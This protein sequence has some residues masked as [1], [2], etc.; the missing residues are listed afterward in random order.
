MRTLLCLACTSREWRT[1]AS[2]SMTLLATCEKCAVVYEVVEQFLKDV[3][4]LVLECA[5]RLLASCY[6]TISTVKV[7]YFLF[8]NVRFMYIAWELS[9]LNSNVVRTPRAGVFGFRKIGLSSGSPRSEMS[10][11]FDL[12]RWPT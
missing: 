6:G 11:L 12:I 10:W 3:R 1:V 2:Q 7:Y 8:P 9:K 5:A 4:A